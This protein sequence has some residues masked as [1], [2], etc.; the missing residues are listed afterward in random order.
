MN[1]IYKHFSKILIL[2]KAFSLVFD[3][4]A[5]Q[6]LMPNPIY[7]YKDVWLESTD[8]F[9]FK[10]FKLRRSSLLVLFLMYKNA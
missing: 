4:M 2:Y 7:I 1:Q 9:L 10:I 3:L 6:T 8:C 5:Y